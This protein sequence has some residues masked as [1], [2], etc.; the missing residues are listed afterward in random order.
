VN[1]TAQHGLPLE[2]E[3][4]L[5]S[6]LRAAKSFGKILQKAGKSQIASRHKFCPQICCPLKSK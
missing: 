1:V 6:G 3:I 5:V 4:E 2:W